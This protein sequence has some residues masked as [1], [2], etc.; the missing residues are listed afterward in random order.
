[1]ALLGLGCAAALVGPAVASASD[2]SSTGVI[3]QVDPNASR[4]ER[5]DVRDALDGTR[6]QR[7]GTTDLYL[8][9]R[10]VPTTD[11]AAQADVAGLHQ[12][13]GVSF[14]L[15]VH[16]LATPTDPRWGEQWG[17]AK[18]GLPA[19]LDLATLRTPVTV[20]VVDT[21]VD[22]T[23]SDLT[24]NIW[25]NPGEIPGDLIDNDH[26]GY[27]DDVHG[28]D[29][30]NG[31]ANPSDDNS[32]GTH[33]AGTIAAGISNGIG[34]A[35]VAPNASIMALKFLNSSGAGT[36]ADAVRALDYAT[37]NGAKVINN[38]WGGD[39]GD[40]TSDPVCQ[41]ITRALAAGATVVSAAGTPAADLDSGSTSFSPA[42]CSGDQLT[43]AATRSDDTLASYS[44][45]GG[46]TVDLGAPGSG[47]LSTIPSD[48]YAF[49][50]G[51]SMAAPHVAG[52]AAVLLGERPGLSPSAVRRDLMMGGVA[53][54]GP[55]GLAGRTASGR[56][57]SLPGALAIL[58][59]A[60]G[61]NAPPSTPDLTAPSDDEAVPSTRP[62]FRWGA[63][64][65][66]SFVTYELL[67]D[68]RTVT[69]GLTGTRA[70]APGALSTGSHSWAV[71][72]TD[73]YGNQGVSPTRTLR[74]DTGAPTA[75]AV[76]DPASGAA[77]TSPTRLAWDAARDSGSGI[78]A[79]RVTLDGAFIGETGAS[80]PQIPVSG[81]AV[82]SHVW[83]VEARDAAG[84]SATGGPWSFRVVAGASRT[85]ING[86]ATVTRRRAVSLAITAPT[87][88]ASMRIASSRGVLREVPAQAVATRVAYDLAATRLR[89]VA[90]TVQVAMYDTTGIR[91][92]YATDTIIL[93]QAPPRGSARVTRVRGRRALVLTA[94]DENGPVRYRVTANG[95][96]TGPWT[97]MRGGIV[98]VA[99]ADPGTA[100]VAF[101][102]R[103]GNTSVAL[104]PAPGRVAMTSRE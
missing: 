44:N 102:D 45:Y 19:A 48:R 92:G 35:G 18:I 62:A 9:S 5:G 76:P 13:D 73:A 72:A 12:V 67:V 52:A 30:V 22:L 63:S 36:T 56:R 94:R 82:G 26:N 101:R 53:L 71:Q 37:N 70:T 97:V 2:P 38:S 58:S 39:T 64:T 17:P 59:G 15:P 23:H 47:I 84:N 42:M 21:G 41:A 27:V 43:V 78:A 60:P 51:T 79:Y 90:R 25:T 31:D 88:A 100:S 81:L 66:E 4:A 34:I 6:I 7:L 69:G 55:T 33:V 77:V 10:V 50:S 28:Y 54:P 1:M 85:V 91:V 16:A 98:H 95:R 40:L 57:L 68:G 75:P 104:T 32:H 29:F 3:V 11:S 65:D 20:A 14:N 80:S 74:V 61:D 99:L 24:A 49:F 103:A 86:G 87:S 96:P 89:S 83:S 93:D 8:V 46:T